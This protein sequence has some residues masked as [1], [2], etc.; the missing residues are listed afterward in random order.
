MVVGGK[1]VV[2][3]SIKRVAVEQLKAAAVNVAVG[4]AFD[5]TLAS[6]AGVSFNIAAQK[7]A[8]DAISASI[9][10]RREATL[11]GSPFTT[12]EEWARSIPGSNRAVPIQYTLKP[13]YT[14]LQGN[15]QIAL[16]QAT[17]AYIEAAAQ[18]MP[19]PTLN[20]TS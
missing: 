15:K 7:A 13:I 20:P 1:R 3:I 19:T 16:R 4:A 6:F 10:S 8:F 17:D 5:S 18:R 14:L 2:G 9:V 12:W 11:G